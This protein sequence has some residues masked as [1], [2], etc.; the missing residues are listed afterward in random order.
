M[1]R[2][3]HAIT[4]VNTSSRCYSPRHWLRGRTVMPK[5][6]ARMSGVELKRRLDDDFLLGSED[7]LNGWLL[8]L[9]AAKKKS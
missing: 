5:D 9:A 8:G 4:A 1:P 3:E 7:R 2:T 6:A